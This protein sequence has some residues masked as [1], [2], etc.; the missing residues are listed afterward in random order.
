[1]SILLSS[2]N[3]CDCISIREILC[4]AEKLRFTNEDARF[5]ESSAVAIGIIEEAGIF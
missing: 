4:I 3:N 1:M 2:E 5:R